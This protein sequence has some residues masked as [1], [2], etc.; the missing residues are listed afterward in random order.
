MSAMQSNHA[1]RPSGTATFSV[2]V[3]IVRV[4]GLIMSLSWTPCHFKEIFRT[5]QQ[6]YS[7]NT[8]IQGHRAA[9]LPST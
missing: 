4:L 1:R 8:A 2:C 5:K 6:T 3:E 9:G 7:Q